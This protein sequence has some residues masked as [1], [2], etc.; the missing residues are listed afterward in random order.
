MDEAER[1]R[2]L[3]KERRTNTVLL[4]LNDINHSRMVLGALAKDLKYKLVG[5]SEVT[6]RALCNANDIPVEHILG[7]A[8]APPEKSVAGLALGAL[9]DK[10]KL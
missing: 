7:P 8:P 4:P 5:V 1:Q 10:D 6:L 2:C 9:M 3:H